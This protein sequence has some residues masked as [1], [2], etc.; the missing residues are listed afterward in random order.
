MN[1]LN[2]YAGIGSRETPVGMCMAMTD[3][4]RQ[5][6]SEWML[7]SGYARGADQAFEKGAAH[8]EIHLPWREYNHAPI[9][10]GY[11]I[12][13]RPT[14]EV[15]DIAAAHHPK[16]DAVYDDGT[17]VLSPAAKLMM[18]RN[19]TIVLGEHLDAPV[20]MIV[21]WTQGGQIKGGTGQALRLAK[22]YDIPVFNMAISSDIDRLIEFVGSC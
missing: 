8:K 16:W 10:R 2:L 22:T 3:L 1:N 13:P 21:C 15:A 4:A 19:V 18:C 9:S 7:R 20:K 17:P 12:T 6:S 11:F 5:L 14:V